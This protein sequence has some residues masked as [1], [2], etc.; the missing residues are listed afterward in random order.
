LRFVGTAKI[1]T[2]G[3]VTIPR[4]VRE[5]TGL[6]IGDRV[7]V[8]A[9]DGEVVVRRA[10]GVLEFEPPQTGRNPLPWPEARRAARDERTARR[11]PSRDR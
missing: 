8:E 3:Q 5:A 4:A 6:D 11:T 2:K 1:Y 9:R 7:I 10:Y